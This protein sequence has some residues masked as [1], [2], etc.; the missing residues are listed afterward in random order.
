M[1]T[2]NRDSHTGAA[3][4]GRS[5]RHTGDT[6]LTCSIRRRILQHLQRPYR[7]A[8]C[9]H[10]TVV[11]GST[12]LGSVHIRHAEHIIR[13][14]CRFIKCLLD[15]ILISDKLIVFIDQAFFL[16]TDHHQ[17]QIFRK[18]EHADTGL[19]LHLLCSL[20]R[21]VPVGH[22]LCHFLRIC[23][24][25]CRLK[26][27]RTVIHG[28]RACVDGN[29]DQLLSVSGHGII[30]FPFHILI[31]ILL[32]LE[33]LIQKIVEL[34]CTGHDIADPVIHHQNIRQRGIG[35]QRSQHLF[36]H[37]FTVE[38]VDIH[39]HARNCLLHLCHQL[40]MDRALPAPHLQLDGIR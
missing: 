27:I 34:V 10:I 14:F 25:P 15:M 3:V 38:L 39:T 13:K 2:G 32:C 11:H 7:S 9:R 36:F 6:P 19:L 1:L 28:R 35:S 24:K 26:Q 31:F 33:R 40:F 12:P 22:Q 17:E 29:G 5:S 18:V 20:Q 4:V 37:I 16:L 21:T 23:G 30:P 8:V